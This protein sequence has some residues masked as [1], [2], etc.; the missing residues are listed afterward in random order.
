MTDA[1]T[2]S[3]LFA[4]LVNQQDLTAEQ[5]AWAMSEI[6]SGDGV[7]VAI[8]QMAAVSFIV[9]PMFETTLA[10]HSARKRGW[11]MGEGLGVVAVTRGRRKSFDLGM[12]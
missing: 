4:A 2:W 7:S 3:D 5:T 9:V 8:V 11:R 12:M 1:P 6:M 10:S